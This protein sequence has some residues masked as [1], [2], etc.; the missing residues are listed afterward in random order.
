MGG[1]VAIRI[2]NTEWPKWDD[3]DGRRSG[4]RRRA[5]RAGPQR[6]A[7]PA[8]PGARRPRR[9]AEV[10]RRRR[11]A[12]CSNG[13]VPA[14]PPPASRSARSPGR[15]CARRSASRSSATWCRSAPSRRPPAWSRGPATASGR[16]LAGAL[17]ATP[18]RARRWSPR[19]TRPSAPATRSAA[20]SRCV[21]YGLPPGLGSHV[22]GDRRLDA[23]L[24]AALMGIQAIK[25]VEVGDGF[26]LA[27]HP[28]LAGARRDRPRP[29][30]DPARVRVDRAAPRAA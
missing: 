11:P 20:S 5:G 30:G 22:Q 9:D 29:T 4:R 3:G 2:G 14:R 18:G 25:G 7:D 13:P 8:P 26:E 17:P 10:R 15:S 27:A 6:A 21:A 24:A 16:R 19:S 23:R 28:R 1:P 12:R